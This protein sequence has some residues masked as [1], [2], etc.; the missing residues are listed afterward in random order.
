MLKNFLTFSFGSWVSAV[1]Q[2]LTVPII[3]LLIAPEQF[4]KAAMFTLAFNV[5]TQI[6]LFGTDQSFVRF[7]YEYEEIERPSLLW[8]SLFPSL[9]VWG[10]VAVGLFFCWRLISNWL[11]SDEQFLIVGLLSISLLINI[12]NRYATL[13]IR[14]QK[15]G[16][17]FSLLQIAGAVITAI[18]I[19]VYSKIVNNTFY[20]IVFGTVCS[21]LI[22]TIIAVLKEHKFWLARLPISRTQIKALLH[23]GL[24]FLPALSMAMIFQVMDRVFIREF[25]GF[26]GLGIYT[27][28]FKIAA[29][30]SVLQAGFSTFWIPVAYEHYEKDPKD[31]TLYEKMFKYVSF[32]LIFCGLGL[33]AGKDIVILMFNATYSEAAAIMPF[34][35]FMPIMFTLSEIT[36]LGINFTKKTYWHI[37]IFAL[38]LPLCLALNFI[39]VPWLGVKGAALA[40]A[41]SYICYF[42]LRTAISIRLYPVNFR[43][44]KNSLAI[45]L[46]FIVAGINTFFDKTIGIGSAVLAIVIYLLFHLPTIKEM[47]V[48]FQQEIVNFIPRINKNN[49]NIES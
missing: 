39:F 6:V 12:F 46:L 18:V 48:Y 27:V 8:N 3:T 44:F 42:A 34:L 1:I 5:L 9:I 21:L 29:V 35:I 30:L 24:P 23:Y 14:M 45:L 26:E 28:A 31:K 2:F 49:Q 36:Y 22:V 47:V 16:V 32:V 43:L 4:G 25:V 33:I 41:L 40:I 19:V 20:A 37:V 10:I 15:K 7:F 11:I 13:V 38:L 17:L